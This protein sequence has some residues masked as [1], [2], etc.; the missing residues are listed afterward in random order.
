MSFKVN[1]NGVKGTH[2]I[3]WNYMAYC[4]DGNPAELLDQ[5]VFTFEVT[6]GVSTQNT[7][8]KERTSIFPNPSGDFFSIENDASVAQVYIYS[9][10]GQ[11]MRKFTHEAGGQYDLSELEKGMYLIR[12]EDAAAHMIATV[13]LM[14]I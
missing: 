13:P 2:S 1:S 4:N 7:E 14:K 8:E 3:T 10:Q 5:V 12:M 9:S 6:G 11:R